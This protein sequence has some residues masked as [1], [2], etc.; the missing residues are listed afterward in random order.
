MLNEAASTNTTF[1]MADESRQAEPR[2]DETSQGES[3]RDE[4][5]RAEYGLSSSELELCTSQ[6]ALGSLVRSPSRAQLVGSM[7]MSRA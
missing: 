2:R 4:P 5:N 1:R 3:R 6:A 7:I